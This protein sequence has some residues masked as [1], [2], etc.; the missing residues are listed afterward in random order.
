[1]A[2]FNKVVKQIKDSEK[3]VDK[4]L[5]A[6]RLERHEKSHMTKEMLEMVLNYII[7]TLAMFLGVG[8]FCFFLWLM[9]H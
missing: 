4:V 1:M 9:G 5:K 3:Q 2:D 6:S 7:G 8:T